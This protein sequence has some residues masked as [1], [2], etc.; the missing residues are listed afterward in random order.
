M[1]AAPAFTGPPQA[2]SNQG[3]IETVLW[4]LLD[5]APPSAKSNQGG[6]ETFTTPLPSSLRCGQN[7]TKVGLKPLPQLV[8]KVVSLGKIEP[9]W[10]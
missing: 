8:G 6:I 10:D 4:E 5:E 1:F 2:K 9:R 3:G 7:R